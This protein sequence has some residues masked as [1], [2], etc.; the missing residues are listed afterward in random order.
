MFINDQC[1]APLSMDYIIVCFQAMDSYRTQYWP[2]A[3]AL[4]FARAF[5]SH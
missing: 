4:A 2:L 1:E 5:G 3:D